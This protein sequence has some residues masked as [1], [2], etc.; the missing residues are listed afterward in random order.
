[1]SLDKVINRQ[2]FIE[3]VSFDKILNRIKSLSGDLDG[4]NAVWITQ[5]AIANMKN[6]IKTRE[7][8]DICANI[9][10]DQKLTNINYSVLASRLL[11]SNLHKTTPQL[12]SEAAEAQKH[13]LHPDI[14]QFIKENSEALD[15]MIEDKRDYLFNYTAIRVLFRSYLIMA[16]R[17]TAD[18]IIDRPQY[19][20][21]RVAVQIGAPC[22]ERIK[23]IYD[24]ISQHYYTHATPTLF[25]SCSNTPQLNSCFLLGTNDDINSIMD[26]LHDASIISKHAGGIGIHMTNIRPKGALIKSTNGNA[27]GVPQQ[28][29]L[30]EAA[31]KTWNQGGRRNGS[32]AIYLEPWHAD[33]LEWLDLRA[34]LTSPDIACRDLFYAIWMN[35]LFMERVKTEG[36]W[37]LFNP[38]DTPGL[39]DAYGEEFKALYERYET[40]GLAMATIPARELMNKI[41]TI[42]R[43]TGMPYICYK[44]TINKLSNQANIG[45]IRSSNLC[46]EI[47]EYSDDTS[48]ACCTLASINVR[49]FIKD[50]STQLP[51]NASYSDLCEVYDFEKL[52]AVVKEVA[53]NL[54]TIIDI[55][56][57]PMRKAKRNA[58]AYRPIAIGIQGLADL[59]HSLKLPFLC[60][61]AQLLD[62]HIAQCIYI[63][64]LEKNIELGEKLGGYSVY[65]TSPLKNGKTAADLWLENQ[66]SNDLREIVVSAQND[67]AGRW[68]AVRE[69]L[70]T[71]KLRNSLMVA[72]MPTASTSTLLN[73]NDSFEPHQNI[74]T[75]TILAGKKIVMSE[76]LYKH[77]NELGYWSE[78]IATNI[79]NN[80]GSLQDLDLPADIKE[81]YKT[82]FELPQRELMRRS[83]LRQAFIDQSQSLNIFLKDNSNLI[84]RSVMM[85]SYELGLKTGSYYIRTLPAVDP[86]KTKISAVNVEKEKPVSPRITEEEGGFCAIGCESCSG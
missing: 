49:A 4:V 58:L 19:M 36:E 23:S 59:F 37:S 10:E 18:T 1:M 26:N 60:E 43:E 56:H 42:Q 74:Y 32:I 11:I 81:L 57:Y 27:S 39:I 54:D 62:L 33:I 69:S 41:C 52:S 48:Y 51:T 44:D 65:E 15:N 6:M 63:S 28:L 75:K 12:F 13:Y 14:L 22:L 30:Y 76:Y 61:T 24:N 34:P 31:A 25:N 83:A 50:N 79:L 73:N 3:N 72:Y 38:Q 68:E 85:R 84:L 78:D 40:E 47:V 7:I 9:A 71:G 45:T 80:R 20:Y 55:N 5:Q 46:A 64:A 8:D 77:L 53:E 2:G 86:M 21:M 70:K 16:N 35:D 67:I 66:K 82:V 29:R 17:K